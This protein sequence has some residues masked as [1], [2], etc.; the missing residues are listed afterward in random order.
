MDTFAKYAGMIVTCGL[1]AGCSRDSANTASTQVQSRD[2]DASSM[3]GL[4]SEG[5]DHN[6]KIAMRD[7]CDPTDPAWAPTGGCLLARGAVRVAEFNAFLRSPLT[8]P[9][10]GS[11][12]GHPAWRNEPSYLS[13]EVGK[14][15]RVTNEGGRVHTFTEV[16]AF[17][18]GRVPPLNIALSPAP[19]CPGSV[20]VAPGERVSL[21]GLPLGIHKFQCC[22]HPWMRAVVRVSPETHSHS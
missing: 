10:N 3:V 13:V 12:V 18:G 9:A 16:A 1:I 5:S 2:A 21:E 4:K 6:R 7:E 20:N 22:I 14:S 8:I 19:E 11:L 15:V 17:G